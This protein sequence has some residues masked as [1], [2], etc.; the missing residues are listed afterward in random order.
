MRC[1]SLF[2]ALAL[3]P[4]VISSPTT[5]S[6]LSARDDR[7]TEIV[8][9]LGAR[10][11]EVTGA[12]GNTRDLAIAMLETNT[13]TTDYTYGIFDIQSSAHNVH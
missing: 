8:S 7:G 1:L 5:G 3:I 12:G 10:K 4:A 9:G 11:Q 6:K 13:M 2:G